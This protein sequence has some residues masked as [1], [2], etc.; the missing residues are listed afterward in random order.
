MSSISFVERARSFCKS[1]VIW[2]FKAV[3][4]KFVVI[5][6]KSINKW[7][8]KINQAQK[9]WR[10]VWEETLNTLTTLMLLDD[11]ARKKIQ[12]EGSKLSQH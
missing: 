9:I 11:I 2:I 10:Y 5:C 4:I 3:M 7:S 12:L 1:V 6:K 8:L